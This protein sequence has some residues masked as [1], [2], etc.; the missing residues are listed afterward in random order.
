MTV[1]TDYSLGADD[2]ERTR[3]LAQCALHRAEAEL[4]L[5]RVGVAPGRRALD[6]GC[7]PLGV[8]DLLAERVGRPAARVARPRP[9]AP[10]AV[11]CRRPP[12]WSRR[13]P[14]S[15]AAGE[16]WRFRTSTAVLDLRP[17][18]S[19]LGPPG[20]G[21]V[22]RGRARGAA[23]AGAAARRGPCRRRGRRARPRYHRLL[24]RFVEIHRG[25]I[26]AA[27]FDPADLDAAIARLAAHL[28]RPDTFTLYATLVQAWGRK[29]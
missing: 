3:L 19:G 4:L 2:T 5:D 20:R 16:S 6:V 17:G 21:R 18:A 13:W 9:R 23:A 14:G 29:P 8:L 25:P 26:P 27:S 1:T 24:L 22:E 12:R 15:P 28:D 11:K 10:P 7:D